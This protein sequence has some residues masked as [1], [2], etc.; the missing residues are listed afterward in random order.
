MFRSGSSPERRWIV[1]LAALLVLT[2]CGIER[3]GLGFIEGADASP[4]DGGRDGALDGGP[5][6]GEDAGSQEDASVDAGP[7]ARDAEAPDAACSCEA[8]PNA[9]V[10][11]VDGTCTL[12]C[13]DGFAD[14]NSVEDDGCEAALGSDAHCSA[15]GDSCA[16]GTTCETGSCTACGPCAC[17]PCSGTCQCTSG[18]A[19]ALTC[20][21]TC[22]IDCRDDGTTCGV[23]TDMAG[24]DAD[25]T[26]RA[27]AT[28]S[29]DMREASN[30]LVTCRDA[31]T[32]CRVDCTDASNC[33]LVQCLAGARCTLDCS[34]ASN[35]GFDACHATPVSCGDGV[36][37]CNSA[38][39]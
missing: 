14:C 37:A 32:E 1:S 4:Q 34:G 30:V 12:A 39:P 38:C 17:G 35:C 25:L 15:C 2:G 36:W 33:D 6:P 29:F 11:C 9:A 10:A 21:G 23:T 3:M 26:C 13:H 18:C 20:T 24:R 7:M 19:C 8:R 28:C 16:S 27:G 22:N 31:N 5:G